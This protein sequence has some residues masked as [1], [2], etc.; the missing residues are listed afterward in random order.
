M[1]ETYVMCYE[2]FTLFDCKFLIIVII[3]SIKI[4]FYSILCTNVN[5]ITI[6]PFY[7]IYTIHICSILLIEIFFVPGNLLMHIFQNY[8]NTFISID[9]GFYVSNKTCR[10]THMRYR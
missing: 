4:E 5:C 1:I 8:Q 6:Y 9:T 10:E 3:I 2:A 7:C